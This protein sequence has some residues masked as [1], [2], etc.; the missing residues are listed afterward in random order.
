MLNSAIVYAALPLAIK[1]S[2]LGVQLRARDDT[3][4]DFLTKAC[5]V[6]AVVD[7]EGNGFDQEALPGI[8]LA[9]SE[10]EDH[11]DTC[12]AV[13]RSAAQAVTRLVGVARRIVMPDV[14]VLYEKVKSEI[15]LRLARL[16][17]PY[18]I[19]AVITPPLF[20][21]PLVLDQ[22][23]KYE[24]AEQNN[25]VSIEFPALSKD[26]IRQKIATGNVDLDKQV[27]ATLGEGGL[28]SIGRVWEGSTSIGFIEPDYCYA[29]YL[30]ARAMYDEPQ[31]GVKLSL[32]QY[33]AQVSW[34][35]EQSALR[36]LRVMQTTARDSRLKLL[37]K[38]CRLDSDQKVILVDNNVYVELLERG[39]SPEAVIGNEMLGR[40]YSVEEL[41]TE[42]VAT[43]VK[44]T[45]TTNME[46]A[47]ATHKVES[48]EIARNAIGRILSYEI[49]ARA[50]E[51][52][53][54]PEVLQQRLL[55]KLS[56]LC[57]ED[58]RCLPE[59]MR[60]LVCDVF[61]AH[62]DVKR[63]LRLLDN[64]GKQRP[65]LDGRNAALIALI[66]YTTAYVAQSI[67]PI[68]SK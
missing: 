15:D 25:D 68:Y 60:D 16:T 50:E 37:Y 8:L 61:Y 1:Q 38:G 48:F 63:Y 14:K 12:D 51:L 34:L 46:V 30:L 27:L 67:E 35:I 24:N 65:D 47:Y 41:L 43:K 5:A 66:E 9:R 21:N 26:E 32:S 49:S 2:E 36:F 23:E 10:I 57:E 31:E 4:L 7:T 17:E 54:Q 62:T 40:K 19:E 22:L 58:I 28:E 42:P 64:I 13:V 11:T 18:A 52:V 29:L 55:D 39:L 53:V 45:Y 6:G 3:A 44:E 59:L 33:N 56:L 20:K